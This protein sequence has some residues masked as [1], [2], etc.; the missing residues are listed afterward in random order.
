[1]KYMTRSDGFCSLC[2]IP[3]TYQTP[4]YVWDGDKYVRN[5]YQILNGQWHAYDGPAMEC[6]GVKQWLVH[7]RRDRVR[8][9]A[10]EWDNGDCEWFRH[11][12]RDRVGGAAIERKNGHY[13]WFRH[14]Q[15]DNPDGPA[16]EKHD[17]SAE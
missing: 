17:G 15:R 10:M 8:G 14:G 12:L 13:E 9:P 5:K 6:H 7:G 3:P 11:G 16:I 4:T 2:Y 1:M